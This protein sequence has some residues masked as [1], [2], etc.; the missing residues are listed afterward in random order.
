MW[1]LTLIPVAQRL[2]GWRTYPYHRA[3]SPEPVVEV[4]WWP[5]VSPYRRA[6]SWLSL[7]TAVLDVRSALVA[8]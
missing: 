1:V 2:Q 3:G 5:N 8:P 6:I 7:G 4:P